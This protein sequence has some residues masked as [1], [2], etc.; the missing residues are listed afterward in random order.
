MRISDFIA[1]IITQRR[2]LVWSGVAVLAL[3]CVA[4]LVTQLRLDSDVL[5]ILPASFRSVAGLKIYDREFEQTRQLTF[6]LVC[7]PADVEKLEEFAPV[8]AG[9]LRQQPWC[10]R[11]LAGSPMATPDGIRDLQSIAVPLLLNLEPSVFDETISILQPRKIRDRFHR[12]RQQIE[13]G[14]PRPEFELSFDPLGLITPALKPF[15]ENTATEQEQPL[16][17]PDGTMRV[18]L[19]VT[20]QPSVSA[21]ECQRLMRRV[22]EFRTTA[23]AEWAGGRLQVLITGRAAFVSEISLSMRYDIVA[24]LL[25]SILLVSCIFFVGFQRWLPLV[26]MAICLLLSC[27]VALTLGQLLFG[28]LSMISVGFCAILVGL[29]VDFAILII[30]RYHQAR[31]DGESHQQA[32]GTSIAKLGRAVFFGAL[33]TA[34]GFVALVLSGAMSFS[35]LGVLIAIGIFIAGL[36]MCSILFL[37]IRARQKPVRHDW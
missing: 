29:G 35:Q 1:Q 16:T 8:F 5:N 17:S 3:A 37:F 12:L 25:G 30:G 7:A 33:T 19:A 27:L 6:A 32:I 23:G 15:A 20:N 10:T 18:F 34:V 36:F 14:S 28:R 2:V 31:S 11:V 4:I 22:N 26:G 13:A 24:T 9:K 21:F